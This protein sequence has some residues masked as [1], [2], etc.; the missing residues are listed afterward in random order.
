M[1]LDP[2]DHRAVPEV[3]LQPQ[4]WLRDPR[5]V[6]PHPP[7]PVG[8]LHLRHRPPRRA[9]RTGEP[10]PQQ[11]VVHP[12]GADHA[13]RLL[14]PGLHLRHK[15]VDQH[16]PSHSRPAHLPG[17]PA[18][19]MRGHRV[20]RTPERLPAGGCFQSSPSSTDGFG[21]E[22]PAHKRPGWRPDS[23]AAGVRKGAFATAGLPDVRARGPGS[24]TV[25]K[26]AEPTSQG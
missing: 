17:V 14:H 4:T 23:S 18:G 5:P 2:V 13:R 21:E 19:H 8:R 15:P 12:I 16:R 20:M 7:Q 25:R 24:P 26:A 22:D 10:Q 1:N 9:L 6:H 11:L 3:V